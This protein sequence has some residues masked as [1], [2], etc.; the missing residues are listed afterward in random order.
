MIAAKIRRPLLI[1]AQVSMLSLGVS[2]LPLGARADEIERS[3][4]VWGVAPSE[5]MFAS[6]GRS[7]LV[8]FG[9]LGQGSG[10]G[11]GVFAVGS[12]GSGVTIAILDSGIDLDHGEFAG[13]IAPGAT[14]F[15]DSFACSGLSLLGY[16]DYG[17]GTHVAGIAAAAND[18]TGKTGVAPGAD[19][20]AVK[21]LSSNG[22]GSYSAIAQG[23]SYASAQGAQV[24]NMS[25]GGPL[26][27]LASDYNGLIAAMKQA[28]QTSV[29]VISA[30]NDGNGRAPLFPAAFA[31]QP[32]IVGSVIIAGSL[33]PDGTTLSRFSNTPGSGGCTG[34]GAARTCFKDVFLVAPG[35]NIFST[36]PGGNY[37]TASGTSMAAPYIS[38]A[39]AV[40]LSA[41]PYLTQQQVV[42]ILFA[43]A[44]DLGRPGTDVV[45]GR[46]LVNPAGAIAPLGSLS[47]A[48]SGPTT[49]SR[50]GTGNVRV[51]GL[52]GALAAGLRGSHAASD[53]V[54][55][56]AYNRDYR[57][58]LTQS[59]ATGAASLA[60]VVAQN[61]PALRAVS[62]AGADFSASG[63]VSEDDGNM[64]AFAGSTNPLAT[65]LRDAVMTVRLTDDAAVTVGYKAGAEGRLNQL[66]LAAS[67]AFD[68]LFMS[69]TAMNSPYLGFAAEA[70]LF[71]ADVAVGEQFSLML[72]HVSQPE[73]S[74]A[75][76]ADEVLTAEEARA[77]LSRDETHVASG[78]G[79]TASLSWRFANWG[80]AGATVAYTDERNALFGG[81]E[82]GAL[83]LTGN[84]DT[85]SVGFGA[86]AN[87]G[88]DWVASASWS[89]GVSRVTPLAGGLFATVS[90]LQTS[91]YG[92]A[93]AK[94][95]LFGDGDSIG[96]GVS[97]PLHVVDGRA[98]LVASTGVTKS[99]EI[100]YTSETIDFASA[101]PETDFELGYTARL[102]P[103]VLFQ[104]NAIYQ[105]N[106]SGLADSEAIAGFATV[107][108][109]W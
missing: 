109:I 95:G 89:T 87:L 18:G 25:L 24:I 106:L 28:A 50:G 70:S 48:T 74:N 69:A 88:N 60:G 63:L 62:F 6:G 42:S 11:I 55:F 44:I 58:N 36:L 12:D 30:G 90:D 108:T 100:I 64:V 86:R 45:Y 66:D 38:G 17:H 84:A 93:L 53:L 14:C 32:G 34:R 54:F 29:I 92:V 1:A 61:G 99:R 41:A 4:W 5:P 102:A 73:R 68:G 107:K 59:L 101:T 49:G 15:G 21:V 40:V 16:D 72:G 94:R 37:G 76:L 27:R 8:D 51:S 82:A 105:L 9:A 80:M 91:A 47:I 52:G 77:R 96:L 19:L 35:E 85:L 13:R 43:S 56:D 10:N 22:T 2:A 3:D 31:T 57:V 39:A 79:S 26:P 97:R 103:G 81:F 71:G 20:L 78:E 75:D 67:E 46:G 7:G 23:I 83:A 33:R 104:A 65:E 98:L